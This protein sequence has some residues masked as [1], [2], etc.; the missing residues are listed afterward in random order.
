MGL[1]FMRRRKSALI[2]G[3]GED[4]RELSAHIAWCLGGRNDTQIVPTRPRGSPASAYVS[5]ACSS[6]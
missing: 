3:A 2:D 6:S 5:A 4:A 1:Q